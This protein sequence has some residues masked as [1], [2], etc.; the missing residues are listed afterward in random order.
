MARQAQ[1]DNEIAWALVNLGTAAMTQGNYDQSGMFLEESLARYKEIQAHEG[2]VLLLSALGDLAL[3]R[4]DY[5]QTV[6]RYGEALILQREGGNGRGIAEFLEKIGNAAS[7]RKQPKTAAI[8]LGAAQ[9]FR[10]S[11]SATHYPFQLVEY[12]RFLEVLRSQLDESIF[13]SL[14]TEGRAMTLDEAVGY[15]LDGS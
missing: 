11:S 15:A 4:G 10:E 12:E 13:A 5:E 3:I 1:D 8:L 9:A 2:V 14:C 6:S 7:T